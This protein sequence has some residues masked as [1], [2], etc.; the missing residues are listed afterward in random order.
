[1]SIYN[2]SIIHGKLL[3]SYDVQSGPK[4]EARPLKKAADLD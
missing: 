2:L 4:P 1:M 3:I